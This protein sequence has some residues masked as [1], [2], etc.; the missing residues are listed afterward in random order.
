MSRPIAQ[1]GLVHGG[2]IERVA[3]GE[4][5][6]RLQP[7]SEARAIRGVELFHSGVVERLLFA[8]GNAH[9]DE[10]PASEA[11]LMASVA[12]K[13]GVPHDKILLEGC[14]SSTIGN[15]ANALEIMQDD[16]TESVVGAT[17]RVARPRAQAIGLA[18]IHHYGLDV[19]LVDYRTT[20]EP[21]GL[22]VTREG[23]SATANA[24]WLANAARKGRSLGEL[25][26]AYRD[27][28]QHSPIAR[29]KQYFTHR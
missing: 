29:V 27:R 25:D 10:L 19:A 21:I 28:R 5:I 9:G 14:S 18:L 15:W 3:P 12:L 4:D 17:G 26:S 16:G 7:G 24:A 13:Q 6:F 2:G 8:G 11:D 20:K 22:S 23:L 1:V